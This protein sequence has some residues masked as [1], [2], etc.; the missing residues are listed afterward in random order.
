MTWLRETGQYALKYHSW[1]N[2]FRNGVRQIEVLACEDTWQAK[3]T[4]FK[5]AFGFWAFDSFVPSP[6]ELTR[7]FA[8]GSY[9]CGFYLPVRI[10]SPLNI[11]WADGSV[12]QMLLEIAR[13]VTT[14][15]FYM[16]AM[17]TAWSALSTWSSIQYAMEMCEQDRY[18]CLLRDGSAP[19]ING[20]H[21][22]GPAFSE[23]IWDPLGVADPN[24][25]AIAIEETSNVRANAFGYAECRG[26]TINS[27]T[28]ALEDSN[29]PLATVGP[30]SGS[31]SDVI[32]WSIEWAGVHDA[33]AIFIVA[34]WNIEPAGIISAELVGTRLT[35][36]QRP[37][38]IPNGGPVLQQGPPFSPYPPCDQ[39]QEFYD[40]MS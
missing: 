33:G 22:G 23:I 27:I 19:M 8:L 4:M 26:H 36:N 28:I 29:G 37:P 3:I 11:I 25:M 31:G 39:V 16:W 18:G 32:P 7:K 9:K 35:V 24:D 13:P 30:F 10:P 5:N 2:P 14:G 40:S 12:A 6:V 21:F 38:S 1:P 15:L 20:E 17:E 34:Y